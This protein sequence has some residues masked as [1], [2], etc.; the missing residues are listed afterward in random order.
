[1]GPVTRSIRDRLLDAAYDAAVTTGWAQARMADIATAAGVSRQTLYDQFG[2]RDA[3][4]QALALRE[5]DRF[6]AGTEQ[7]LD[8][9]DDIVD[10]IEAAM[11]Y[12]LQTA[13]DNPLVHSLITENGEEGLL[14]LLTTRAEPVL[15]ASRER[16]LAYYARRYP[17]LDAEDAALVAE[18]GTRLSVSYILQP[19]EPVEV[20]A[21][22]IATLVA[23]IL[24]PADRR[25]S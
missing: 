11:R 7:A 22:R 16:M 13:Q 4:A 3:L 5:L 20:T 25:S 15:A 1:M 10:A 18:V 8:G 19:V 21:R 6:L 17:E 12:V 9:E 14:P 23:R 2:S 24:Q